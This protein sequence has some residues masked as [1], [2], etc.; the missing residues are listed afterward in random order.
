MF[1][2][3][4]FLH[5]LPFALAGLPK[6]ALG[7]VTDSWVQQQQKQQ[8]QQQQQE[9]VQRHGPISTHLHVQSPVSVPDDKEI[10]RHVAFLERSV[11]VRS[12][13][14][15][16]AAVNRTQL[17]PAHNRAIGEAV[18]TSV[19]WVREWKPKRIN[20]S[21]ET[22]FMLCGYMALVMVTAYLFAS[23]G[24]RTPVPAEGKIPRLK[25]LRGP[26][27]FYFGAFEV[28]GCCSRD[29]PLCLCAFACIGIRW[30]DT[31]S[32]AKLNLGTGFYSCVLLHTLCFGLDPI[33]MGISSLSFVI[34]AVIYRQKLRRLFGIHQASFW[35]IVKDFILWFC[36]APCAAAQE[37]R[38]VQYMPMLTD[39]QKIHRK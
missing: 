28:D 22:A 16:E 23:C 25:R 6:I 9:E 1:L 27:D 32:Q 11:S 3:T 30:G 26:E 21:H 29:F 20:L 37:A 19:G 17:L 13:V 35:T 38:E 24:C 15:D 8:Q 4:C 18:D 34:T 10:A 31:L 36:C 2:Q 7:E 39:T 12:V 33:T 14:K 5:L